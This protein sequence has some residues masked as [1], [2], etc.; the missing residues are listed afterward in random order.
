MSSTDA[1]M[2]SDETAAAANSDDKV[3]NSI[4]L[5]KTLQLQVQLNRPP[6]R[7]WQ[8]SRRSSCTG[9]SRT[10]AAASTLRRTA[11]PWCTRPAAASPS[12]T[13]G[14]GRSDW[15]PSQTGNGSDYTTLRSST[16]LGYTPHIDFRVTDFRVTLWEHPEIGHAFSGTNWYPLC[17]LSTNYRVF[18]AM[19]KPRC[20]LDFPSARLDWLP[21][22]R[23]LV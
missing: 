6:C 23:S 4:E 3:H 21:Y 16:V 5:H 15:C 19:G 9:S 7:A 18:N 8:P 14:R 22:K 11:P 2:T 1:P 13:R 12:S 10:C 20:R 17:S